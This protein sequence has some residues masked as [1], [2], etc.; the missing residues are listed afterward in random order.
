MVRLVFDSRFS[1]FYD[2]MSNINAR[3]FFF[4]KTVACDLSI[5]IGV[6]KIHCKVMLVCSF[7]AILR[8]Y[9]PISA[10]VRQK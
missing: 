9:E 3:M 7:D 4:V 5:Y 10:I 8:L 6:Y 2:L 1:E